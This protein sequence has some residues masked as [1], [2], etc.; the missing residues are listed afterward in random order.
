MQTTYATIAKQLDKLHLLRRLLLQKPINHC[1]LYAGQL[2]ILEYIERNGG[3]TQA[4]LSDTMGVTPA[5]I[6]LSTKRLQRVGYI[7]KHTDEQD[8]R[9]NQLTITEAGKAAASQCRQAFDALDE[10]MFAGISSQELTSFGQCLDRLID[11][12]LDAGG[13]AKAEFSFR[14]LIKRLA[15]S[16]TRRMEE[17]P[18][19]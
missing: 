4:A 6:A 3:C 9:R 10:K 8:L 11:N 14:E 5:S 2:P 7:E 17:L 15:N 12:M 1:G 13:M 19:D 18:H 16:D